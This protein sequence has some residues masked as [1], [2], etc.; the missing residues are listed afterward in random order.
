MVFLCPIGLTILT[1]W[2]KGCFDTQILSV[3]SLFFKLFSEKVCFC[4]DSC[5]SYPFILRN[6]NIIASGKP[7]TNLLRAP[8]APSTSAS[9]ALTTPFCHGSFS[10][11]PSLD[12]SSQEQGQYFDHGCISSTQHNTVNNSWKNGWG[13]G[14]ETL[15]SY[16]WLMLMECSFNWF[17]GDMLLDLFTTKSPFLFLCAVSLSESEKT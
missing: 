9:A 15:L 11:C 4:F 16:S 14:S 3:Y 13:N 17:T 6:P 10:F 12:W 8:T 1:M 2:C 5:L 7:S